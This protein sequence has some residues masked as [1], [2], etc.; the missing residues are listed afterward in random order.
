MNGVP[1][2]IRNSTQRQHLQL[3]WGD[4]REQRLEHVELRRQCPC[5]QCR[6]FRLQGLTPQV[7]P[8]VR[9]LQLNPQGYGLQLVFS[10]GHDRGIY[11]WAYL[12]QMA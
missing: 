12:A 11:P 8:N 2:G 6:A 9:V 4:G 10:D 7:A 3:T 5:A 1:Q